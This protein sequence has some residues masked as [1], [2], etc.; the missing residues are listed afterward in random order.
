MLLLISV[1]GS[2]MHIDNVHFLRSF[3]FI[4]GMCDTRFYFIFEIVG[5]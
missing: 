4:L 2:L 3:Y 1:R 5:C